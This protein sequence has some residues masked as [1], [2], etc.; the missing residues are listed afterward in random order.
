M[1]ERWRS[2]EEL[3]ADLRAALDAEAEVPGWF[4]ETGKAA[5]DWRSLDAELA[6][7]TED[8]ATAAEPAGARAEPLSVRSLT[9]TGRE[10]A[11][12]IEVD[13]DELHGQLA[14]PQPGEIEV[15]P[16]RGQ[17]RRVPVDDLGW[18][19]VRPK[20]AGAFRLLFRGAG[21]HVVVTGWTTL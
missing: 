9:F 2:D 17:V 3:L 5:L 16:R 20:P 12:G 21:G 13:P 18:F 11:I 19:V 15:H 14:P 4:V 10:I 6:T 1:A 8:S 7:L